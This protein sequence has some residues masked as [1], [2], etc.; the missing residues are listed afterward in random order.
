MALLV[1]AQFR[2]WVYSAR[3]LCRFP[4]TVYRAMPVSTPSHRIALCAVFSACCCLLIAPVSAALDLLPDFF[5]KPK[6]LKSVWKEQEQYVAL[7]T[8]GKRDETYPPN[9]HPATLEVEDVRDALQS[10]EVWSEGGFFRNE[11]AHPVFTEVQSAVLG[12]YVADALLKAKPGEDV[13]FNVRGYGKVALDTFREREW[14][15]GRVFFA[16]GKLNLII[17]TYRTKKDRG[18]KSAEGA[19]GIIDNYSDIYFDPGSRRK[20]TGKMEGRIV[21]SA[22]VSVPTAAEGGRTDWVALDVPLAAQAF[23]E[24]LIPEEQKKTAEKSKQEAA[25]LTIERRQMREEMARLRQQIKELGSG[26]GAA[27]KTLEERL[28]T[29]QALRAKDLITDE[30]YQRRRDEILKDI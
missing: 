24:A 21:A 28:A 22:G 4:L 26:A 6:I 13:I 15:S 27:S 17:G 20:K 2:T 9:A 14:T 10:L 18:I 5:D 16:D 11:E 23:R 30:E 7:T 3:R 1:P 25:K 12:R 29:L 19:Y 8:Q